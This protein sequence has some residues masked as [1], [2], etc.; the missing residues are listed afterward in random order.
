MLAPMPDLAHI[1]CMSERRFS[2]GELVN[3]SPDASQHP[4]TAK[5]LYVIVGLVPDEIAGRSYRI[6]HQTDGHE[7]IA[8]E[9][10]LVKAP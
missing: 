4:D 1:G 6:R 8:R 9:H 3:Y 2:L 5:G 10:Q 7:R